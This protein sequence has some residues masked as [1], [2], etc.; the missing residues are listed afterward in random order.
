MM[1]FLRGF[2]SYLSN[3]SQTADGTNVLYVHWQLIVSAELHSLYH[4]LTSDKLSLN[5][6]NKK[7]KTKKK[8]Q[9]V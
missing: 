7:N 6:Q 2:S 4:W 8:I 9:T 3:R 5:K 1:V